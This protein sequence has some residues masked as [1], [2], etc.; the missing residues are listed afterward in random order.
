LNLFSGKSRERGN[1]DRARLR[2][3]EIGDSPFG[4]VFR[5]NYYPIRGFY[6][7]CRE[8]GRETPDKRAE[9]PKGKSAN[10]MPVPVC[11]KR[12]AVSVF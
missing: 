6:A 11:F 12:G 3:A 4:A 10:N 9:F 7:D 5:E 8:Q 2:Y 1:A